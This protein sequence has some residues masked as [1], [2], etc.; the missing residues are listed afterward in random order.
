M[1]LID[2]PKNKEEIASFLADG[3]TRSTPAVTS[4]DINDGDILNATQTVDLGGGSYKFVTTLPSGNP[5]ESASISADYSRRDAGLYWVEAVRGAIIGEYERAVEAAARA[6]RASSPIETGVY[7][8]Q[9]TNNQPARV[10]PNSVHGQGAS[11]HS[12]PVQYAKQQLSAALQRLA[13]ANN[14]EADVKKWSAM[15]AM[16][17]GD[18][19][20][21]RRKRRAK[22]P[23]T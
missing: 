16:L 12:D 4:A 7:D 13:A 3:N 11:E 14:A 9:A 5:L 15:V 17:T 19:P 18:T 10:T 1:G 6:S 23:N 8:G 20:K 2:V 22:R 21:K